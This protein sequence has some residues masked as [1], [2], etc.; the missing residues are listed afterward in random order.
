MS[1]Y[2]GYI[3][4]QQPTIEDLQKVSFYTPGPAV[5]DVLCDAQFFYGRSGDLYFALYQIRL[6]EN[7]VLRSNNM[8]FVCEESVHA[9]G[10]PKDRDYAVREILTEFYTQFGTACYEADFPDEA[11]RIY[12]VDG[13]NNKALSNLMAQMARSTMG[14]AGRKK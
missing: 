3:S 2:V 8:Y 7:S 1:M 6:H 9:S 10:E 5:E 4:T 14:I 12:K 13:L 11:R